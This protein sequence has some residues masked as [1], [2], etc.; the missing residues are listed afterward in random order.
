[1][2]ARVLNDSGSLNLFQVLIKV[3]QECILA[4]TMLSRVFS[5]MLTEAFNDNL[6]R[7]PII[8]WSDEKL[9]SLQ[10]LQAI[11]KNKKPSIR[12]FLF[13]DDCALNAI[14]EQEMQQFAFSCEN[15]GL[16]I[17]T[18]KMKV[19]YQSAPKNIK[20]E[21]HDSVKKE[22][23]QA[24]EN[25]TY[26]GS[27]LSHCAKIDYKFKI[28]ITEARWA[29]GHLWKKVWNKRGISQSM[30]VKIYKTVALTTLSL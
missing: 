17:N 8:Y 1:M 21:S 25:F 2:L 12:D 7:I 27:T 28:K 9:F 10:R 15:F 29:F 30:K 6:S 26:L 13:S 23:L 11:T 20:Q 22:W 19:M 18:Q 14:T 16:T 24:V 4:L 3:K 5:A